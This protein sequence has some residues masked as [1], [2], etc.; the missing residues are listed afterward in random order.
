MSTYVAYIY[1]PGQHSKRYISNNEN[2]R[3]IPCLASGYDEG[4]K[5]LPNILIGSIE[6]MCR[7]EVTDET[8]KEIASTFN[9]PV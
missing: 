7:F 1:E 3:I 8:L 9:L 4:S 6:S 2:V 5:G